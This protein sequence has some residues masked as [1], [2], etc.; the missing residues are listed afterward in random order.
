MRL[1]VLMHLTLRVMTID[2]ADFL[3]VR[4]FSDLHDI[5]A[6]DCIAHTVLHIF[7]QKLQQKNYWIG[8]IRRWSNE[9]KPSV[10]F[11]VVFFTF[12]LLVSIHWLIDVFFFYFHTR[13]FYSQ[14]RTIFLLWKTTL[15]QCTSTHVAKVEISRDQV[16]NNK[17]KSVFLGAGAMC[18]YNS[19]NNV[20]PYKILITLQSKQSNVL[21]IYI[22][23]STVPLTIHY[24]LNISSHFDEK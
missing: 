24:G 5:F 19:K 1:H 16:S 12:H 21:Y 14:N 3:R 10:C 20:L 22:P 4:V 15:K 6:E 8:Y 9:K 17:Q 13:G 23:V 11:T 2:F 7:F 18:L